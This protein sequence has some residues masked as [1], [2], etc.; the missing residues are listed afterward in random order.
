MVAPAL[1]TISEQFGI[2]SSVE[3]QLVLSIFVL[4][5][6]TGPLFFGPMSEIYGRVPVLQLGNLFYLVFN[7]ACGVSRN[8]GEMIAFR[9]LSGLG[10]SAPLAVSCSTRQQL[11]QQLTNLDWRRRS[12]RLLA[13]RR[14]WSGNINLLSRSVPRPH[15]SIL[16]LLIL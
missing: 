13:G 14:A 9:F 16:H 10:G 11:D 1:V 6:A 5:Y 12:Q 4:G 3:G 8:K 15:I 2:T 7:I